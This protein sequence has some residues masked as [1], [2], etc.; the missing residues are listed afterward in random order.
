MPD[1]LRK[2]TL[3]GQAEEDIYFA[4]R[5]R[6]LIEAMFFDFKRYDISKVGRWK[7]WQRLP[8]LKDKKREKITREC[9]QKLNLL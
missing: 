1:L 8:E 7:T 6:E 2:L 5:E 4:K 3:K 9:L